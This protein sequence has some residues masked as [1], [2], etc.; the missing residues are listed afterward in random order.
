M[1]PSTMPLKRRKV[2]WSL[3]W[4]WFKHWALWLIVPVPWKSDAYNNAR[5]EYVRAVGKWLAEKDE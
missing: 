5:L 1:K 4:L 3:E 2:P